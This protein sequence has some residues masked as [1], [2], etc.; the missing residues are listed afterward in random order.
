MARPHSQQPLASDESR[1]V[2]QTF[3][4]SGPMRSS[5]I[6][7]VEHVEIGQMVVEQTLTNVQNSNGQTRV[8][9]YRLETLMY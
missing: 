1:G 7:G 9:I 3:F 8:Y 4:S 5:I 2:R 6:E